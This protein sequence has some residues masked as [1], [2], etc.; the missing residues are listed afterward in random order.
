MSDGSTLAAWYQ[1]IIDTQD[2]PPVFR[3]FVADLAAKINRGEFDGMVVRRGHRGAEGEAQ[4]FGV[5]QGCGEPA[6]GREGGEACEDGEVAEGR[7]G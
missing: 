5:A 3:Q 4:G 6:G 2:N 1:D 7:E